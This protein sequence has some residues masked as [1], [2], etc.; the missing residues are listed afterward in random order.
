MA[1]P[2]EIHQESRSVGGM[3]PVI[4]NR[5]QEAIS[6]LSPVDAGGDHGQDRLADVGAE[7]SQLFA[8][9]TTPK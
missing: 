3:P 4:K 5:R 6:L 7:G 8:K 2:T 9:F 1:I